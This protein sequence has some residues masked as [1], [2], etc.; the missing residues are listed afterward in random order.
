MNKNNVEFWRRKRKLKLIQ[1][2]D[3]VG[4][5]PSTIS[6][7]ESG[8]RAAS[9]LLKIKIANELNVSIYDLFF[10][11]LATDFQ[12]E[13]EISENIITDKKKTR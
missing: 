13:I 12:K 10:K 3:K 9:D 7:I 8:E 4:C 5:S 11:N 6:R 2:A 1:L